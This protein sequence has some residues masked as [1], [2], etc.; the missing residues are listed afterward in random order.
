MANT[1]VPS[2]G[3]AASI[4]AEGLYFLASTHR[5]IVRWGPVYAAN[6]T[7]ANASITAVD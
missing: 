7:L 6:N 4:P 5:R 1:P 3:T 2:T